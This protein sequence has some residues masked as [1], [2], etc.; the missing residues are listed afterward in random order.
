MGCGRAKVGRDFGEAAQE[1][2]TAGTVRDR[3]GLRET[4]AA[5]VVSRASAAWRNRLSRLA[6][7]AGNLHPNGSVTRRAGCW[8]AVEAG[9]SPAR[10]P[11]RT[12]AVSCRKAAGAASP[13]TWPRPPW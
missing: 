9:L 7:G 2:L 1:A 3:A 4:P 12:R 8:R 5:V 11:D 13:G 10:A 6:E